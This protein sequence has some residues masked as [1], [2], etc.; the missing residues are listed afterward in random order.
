LKN[1]MDLTILNIQGGQTGRS[2][3]LS[4][5]VFG[6]ETPSDHAIYQD[7]RYILANRR[8]GTHKAKTR[9]EVSGTTKKMYRQKGT[10]NARQGSKRSPLHRHGGRVFGPTPHEYGFSM[11]KKMRALARKSALTY[12]ARTAAV[13]VVENFQFDAPKTKQFISVLDS[14]KVSGK[15]ILF[16]LPSP[17]A[18][19]IAARQAKAAEGKAEKKAVNTV[20]LSGRNVPKVNI[21]AASDINTFDIMNAEVLVLTEGALGFINEKL[22]K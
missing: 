10:G 22:A 19:D 1:N 14:L 2:A 11:N 15:K 13:T 7:V 17:S 12:K 20:Y 3:T 9:A 4:P 8:Q 18:E 16:V 5:E 6:L 21:V